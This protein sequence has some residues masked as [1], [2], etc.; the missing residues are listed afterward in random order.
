MKLSQF[1]VRIPDSLIAYHPAD[2]R[3]E[4]RLMVVHRDTG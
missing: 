2:H 4:S 1:K 3:D